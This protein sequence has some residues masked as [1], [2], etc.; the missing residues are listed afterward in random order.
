MNF[1]Y[2]LCFSFSLLGSS[3]AF[4]QSPSDSSTT[5]S[6]FSI[7]LISPYKAIKKG[8]P[9]ELGVQI[10][11]QEDWYTYWSF[12]GDFGTSPLFK[13]QN[14]EAIQIK[15]LPMPRPQRKDLSLGTEKFYSFIY[16]EELL[17]PLEVLVEDS[18]P[19]ETLDL[20]LILEWGLCKDI[21]INQTTPLKL[22]L[23]I[24]SEFKEKASHKIIFDF[25]K[26]RFPQEDKSLNLKSQFKV[27]DLKPV[28]SFSFDTPIHCLD[29][30]PQSLLDF[31]T[32]KPKL[33]QQSDSS[34]SF[35]L[36]K[37][38][39]SMELTAQDSNK[40][41]FPSEDSHSHKTPDSHS[42]NLQHQSMNLLSGLFIY[43]Q[44]GELQSR[45]F[46]AQ[47]QERLAL[48]WFI[49]MAFLGGL[50]LNVMPCVLP[51][52]FLKFYN[53]LQIQSYSTK[54]QLLLN[55]SYAA[56]VILSFLFL[57]FIIFLA[58][59]SGE[60]LGWG[61]HL[62]SPL[63][64]SILALLFTLMGLYLLDSFSFSI[65]K[66]PKLFKDE[67]IL[68]H[69][70][71]GIL[72]TTAASPC[73]V[74]FMASAVGFA[75]SRTYLEIFVIFFFLGFG[76]SFP[77]LL[78]SFFPQVFKFVP[79]PGTWSQT[80]KKVLSLPLFLTSL[81]LLSILYL[82]VNL[83]IFVL[84]LSLFPLLIGA[85]FIPPLF[86]KPFL[87][88]ISLSGCL[89]FIVSLFILQTH[90]NSSQKPN[91]TKKESLLID[92]SWQFFDENLINELRRQEKN[93]FVAFG[94]EWCLTCKFNQRLFKT[95]KFQNLIEQYDIQLFYGD[96]TNKT[97]AITSFLEKYTRQ[98]VPFY[99][100][101]QGEKKLFIFPSL[102]TEKN[103]LEKLEE[104]AK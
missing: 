6:A 80:L 24:N 3:L 38:S 17:I 65:P 36:T 101:Y 76:L 83:N 54:K 11:M 15:K 81:W 32:Q 57:A 28:L 4:T 56:G 12:A 21:C 31:S 9:F 13:F 10:K 89:V 63:F 85:V 35:E 50:I 30:L 48:I 64:V 78:L 45:L 53:N 58:K 59:K 100:F 74:P 20:N 55:G 51:I 18:Y 69:F 102:L 49:F 72:S 71:T 52:I 88:K 84:S 68:S 62:Q 79:T 87:Q 1:F 37:S 103:F 90:L 70:F 77:Y 93:L 42:K 27:T 66:L 94:A 98:G 67:K 19:E 47:R 34:C 25:W 43:S 29:V 60:S 92:S 16:E 7:R 73:T 26:S 14:T 97:D 75:F 61:F 39:S 33:L 104:L 22:S 96:W 5:D 44:K 86:S 91:P 8:E 82:Q 41:H 2:K 23:K 46:T 40:S 95:K 99:I